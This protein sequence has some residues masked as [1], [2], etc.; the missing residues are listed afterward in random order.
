MIDR[1]D[2]LQALR[3]RILL[4]LHQ[5]RAEGFANTAAALA[6]MLAQV[7]RNLEPFALNRADAGATTPTADAPRDP[8][9]AAVPFTLR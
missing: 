5:A 7:D 4:A 6:D 2:N 9:D 8:V 3:D 1:D